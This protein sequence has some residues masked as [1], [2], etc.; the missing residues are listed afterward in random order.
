MYHNL[1]I[2]RQLQ[3]LYHVHYTFLQKNHINEFLPILVDDQINLCA[4]RPIRAAPAV[5][6]EE[7]PIITGPI[8]SKTDVN[9]INYPLLDFTYINT[10]LYYTSSNA[11]IGACILIKVSVFNITKY[12]HSIPIMLHKRVLMFY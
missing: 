2:H 3:H 8:I 7:G 4:T 5:C 12:C 11:Y 10:L 9:F 6:E 1:V